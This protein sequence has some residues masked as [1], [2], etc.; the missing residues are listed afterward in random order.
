MESDLENELGRW[1]RMVSQ[2]S[3]SAEAMK[4]LLDE[5]IA[6]N[7]VMKKNASSNIAARIS[8]QARVDQLETD[9][10]ALKRIVKPRKAVSL[11]DRFKR[12]R[13]PFS[14]KDLTSTSRD[15]L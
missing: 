11:R 1:D 13:R 6:L 7:E 3:R 4:L 15:F 5:V 14:L 12:R 10:E 8:L 2:V 9:V